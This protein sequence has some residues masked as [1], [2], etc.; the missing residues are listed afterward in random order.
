MAKKGQMKPR[1]YSGKSKVR[2]GKAGPSKP[3]NKVKSVGMPGGSSG[4][5]IAHEGYMT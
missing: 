4:P 5:G 3:G 1:K 2:G